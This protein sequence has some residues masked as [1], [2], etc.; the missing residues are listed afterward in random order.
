MVRNVKGPLTKVQ[1]VQSTQS[2]APISR[3]TVLKPVNSSKP[4]AGP[5]RTNEVTSGG[6]TC[7]ANHPE[8]LP[9]KRRPVYESNF[10]NGIFSI[11]LYFSQSNIPPEK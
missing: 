3:V 8:R 5:S 6:Q 4:S 9:R 1:F 7:T 2:N 10:S 11:I